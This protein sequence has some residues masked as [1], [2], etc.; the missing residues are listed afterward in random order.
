MEPQCAANVVDVDDVKLKLFNVAALYAN[1]R[2]A[3]GRP[4]IT[5]THT[6][7]RT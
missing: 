7:T 6:L 3:V 2:D 1:T 4:T 5:Q